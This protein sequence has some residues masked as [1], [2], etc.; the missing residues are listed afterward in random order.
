[1]SDGDWWYARRARPRARGQSAT[2]AG[3][4]PEALAGELAPRTPPCPPRTRPRWPTRC[5]LRTLR[6]LRH[7]RFRRA[8][9]RA[10]NPVTDEEFEDLLAAGFGREAIHLETRDSYGT[11]AELPHMAQWA[12]GEHDAWNGSR[13]WCATLREHAR[14]G[15]SVRRARIVSE[16]LSDYKRWSY[17]IAY[18]MVQ[19]GEDI[20]WVPRRRYRTVTTSPSSS[21]KQAQKWPCP[22][23]RRGRATGAG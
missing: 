18:P 9:G 12:R 23:G 16:P 21:G 5:T 6:Q 10:V 15:R 11:E 17:G 13:G 4:T 22:A 19:A 3:A 7:D 1:M 2:V 20:R 8:G 14:A